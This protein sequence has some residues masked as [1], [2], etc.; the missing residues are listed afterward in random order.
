M[1]R[2]AVELHHS[3]DFSETVETLV[4][5]A[6]TL[7]GADRAGV[8]VVTDDGLEDDLASDPL[9]AHLD[10]LQVKLLEGPAILTIAGRPSVRVKTMTKER[11]WQQ[12]AVAASAAGV[13]SS[14]SVRLWAGDTT[15]GALTLYS[16]STNAFHRDE[17]ALAEIVARHASIALGSARRSETLTRAVDVRKLIGQAQGILMERFGLD[18]RKAFEILRVFSRDTHRTLPQVARLVVGSRLITLLPGSGTITDLGHE[19]AYRA[20]GEWLPTFR[21]RISDVSGFSSRPVASHDANAAVP[22]DA[23][24]ATIRGREGEL[25]TFVTTPATFAQICDWLRQHPEFP[26]NDG[27]SASVQ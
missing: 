8:I 7:I 3:V 18:D 9:A 5:A 10:G 11:R 12:W 13:G 14:L 16:A 25:A 22:A 2:L 20:P 6:P 15:L 26:A 23:V 19:V 4:A 24:I 1:A 17:I 21:L 27:R